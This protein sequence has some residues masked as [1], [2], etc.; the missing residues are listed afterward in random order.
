M[1]DDELDKVNGG[2]GDK[3][4]DDGAVRAYGPYPCNSEI[5]KGTERLFDPVSGSRLKCRYCGETIMQ[6]GTM[7]QL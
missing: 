7:L 2:S 6:A 3:G 4:V 5:C 1:K